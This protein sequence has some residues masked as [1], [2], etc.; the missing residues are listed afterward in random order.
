M[1]LHRVRRRLEAPRAARVAV[2]LDRDRARRVD[3]RVLRERRR[4]RI[5][6]RQVVDAGDLADLAI[7]RHQRVAE[8][9]HQ[10]RHDDQLAEHR[11][12]EP[13]GAAPRIAS[14]AARRVHSSVQRSSVYLTTRR[15]RT[16][17]RSSPG[18]GRCGDCARA[19][20]SATRLR[21]VGMLV[22]ITIGQ[23]TSGGVS[24]VWNGAGL[25]TVHSR[26]SAPSH[27]LSAA[28]GPALD[29]SA[30]RRRTGSRPATGRSRT[31]RSSRPG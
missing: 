30:A 3:L 14:S 25:G 15:R 23:R 11:R 16:R 29:A 7:Q 5:G 12:V 13:I 26:P 1:H 31:R 6:L 22:V 27:G 4:A 9:E 19:C 28:F 8:A 24:N 10:R 17:A 20:R 2:E 18:S 21:R